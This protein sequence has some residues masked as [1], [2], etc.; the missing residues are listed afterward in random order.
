MGQAFHH[1]GHQA[2]RRETA[3]RPEGVSATAS[4]RE[5][6]MGAKRFTT[7]LFVLAI[8]TTGVWANDAIDASAE[9]S[10]AA[11]ETALH[12][13]TEL[14]EIEPWIHGGLPV[15]VKERVAAG[16]AIAVRK[17]QD[18]PECRGLFDELGADALE[19]LRTGLYLPITSHRKE[20]AVCKGAMAFTN[21]GAASTFLCRD[22]SRMS[23]ERAAMYVIHEAL[24]HAGLT[25]QPHDPGAMTSRA[26]NRM[27]TNACKL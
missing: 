7:V 4:P 25:E 20:K 27:V 26:I 15:D 11:G 12:S 23:D 8:S 21:V 6:V 24:H 19:T 9:S 2:G 22:F 3:R 17:V 18:V 14:V 10:T 1:S 16:F 5:V 13:S